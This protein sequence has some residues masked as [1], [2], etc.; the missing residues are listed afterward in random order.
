MAPAIRW[1][2]G[3]KWSDVDH[4]FTYVTFSRNG[5]TSKLK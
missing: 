1:R 4:T 2:T 5:G 3:I